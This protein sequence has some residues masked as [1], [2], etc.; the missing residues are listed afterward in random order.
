MA[1]G[2]SAGGKERCG[3]AGSGHGQRFQG[4]WRSAGAGRCHALGHEAGALILAAVRGIG[5]DHAAVVRRHDH[6]VL[7]PGRHRTGL[8]KAQGRRNQLPDEAEGQH[9]AEQARSE[10]QWTE[11]S[12]H[13][14]QSGDSF[15]TP[16][17]ALAAPGSH[18]PA[19]GR[20]R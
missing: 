17:L 12:V 1:L 7:R 11:Q 2:N 9:G 18:A 5:R 13:G 16:S 15:N 3:G 6:G 19:Q 20:S 4:R 8:G 14:T 10:W